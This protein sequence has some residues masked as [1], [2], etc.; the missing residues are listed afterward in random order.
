MSG[1]NAGMVSAAMNTAGQ[2]GGTLSPIVFA[3]ITERWESAYALGLIAFLYLL[4]AACWLV[5]RAPK[6]SL[7]TSS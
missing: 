3:W 6:I 7:E 2:I 4:G 5:V 1:P